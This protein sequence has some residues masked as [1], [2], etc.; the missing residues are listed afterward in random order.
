MMFDY[1]FAAQRAG[2]SSDKLDYLVSIMRAEFPDDEA[3]AELQ[4]SE[5]T[6]R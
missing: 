5:R 3:M 6:S 1:A 2:I 4:S